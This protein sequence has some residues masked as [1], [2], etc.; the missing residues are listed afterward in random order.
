MLQPCMFRF[1]RPPRLE[2]LAQSHRRLT[3]MVSAARLLPAA[4]ACL[5]A[6]TIG[7]SVSQAQPF[8]RLPPTE[9]AMQLERLPGLNDSPL[10]DRLRVTKPRVLEFAGGTISVQVPNGWWAEEVPAGREIRLVMAQ[11]RPT[12]IR[13][14]PMDNMW[15]A[16]HAV[17]SNQSVDAQAM[18]RELSIRLRS[19][20]GSEAAVSAPTAFQFG[21]WPAVVS[22]FS[23]NATSQASRQVTGRH[24]LVRTEW[25]LFEFHASA[26]DDIVGLR[27]EI[28][29][30][31]WD[32]LKLNPP[33][34]PNRQ[35][36]PTSASSES[37]VG[38]WKSYRSRM[39]FTGEGRV[40]LTPDSVFPNETPTTLRGTY[41]AR[42]DLIFVRWNDGSRLNFRWRL[43]ANDLFLTDH[44][45]QISQL[46]RVFN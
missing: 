38:N 13:K 35:L 33:A 14:M 25:G 28:W 22:E 6:T 24:V 36:T 7:T 41:E 11:R 26:P 30:A 46:K 27:S 43:E 12:N 23:A 2:V 20:V 1:L 37:I 42:D 32:S 15:L 44:E 5:V 4:I 8:D 10:N 17:P 40:E 16:Y 45:G 21:D 9:Q 34:T 3:A 39:N 18:M 29:T 19:V 31:T